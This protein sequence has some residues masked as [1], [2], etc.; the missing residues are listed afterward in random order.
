MPTE[1]HERVADAV[2]Q[3]TETHPWID[4]QG[5]DE[6]DLL[7]VAD[8]ALVALGLDDLTAAAIRANIAHP[9]TGLQIGT[10]CAHSVLVAALTTC[11]A[12]GYVR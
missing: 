2:G 12:S 8:A 5:L 1:L 4:L 3:L 6:G 7:V 9:R 10:D 11:T